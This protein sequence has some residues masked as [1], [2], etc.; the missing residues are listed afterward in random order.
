MELLEGGVIINC[1]MDLRLPLCKISRG[2]WGMVYVYYVS[3][4]RGVGEGYG[5]A[6]MQLEHVCI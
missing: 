5:V 4:R 3:R 1:S 6:C 2:G